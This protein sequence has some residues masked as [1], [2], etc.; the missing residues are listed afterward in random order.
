MCHKPITR[1]NYISATMVDDLSLGAPLFAFSVR[2]LR[3][4]YSGNCLRVRRSNDNAEQDI[5]FFN[6]YIDTGALAT[7]VGANSAYVVTWYD[8]SGNGNNATQATTDRQ[9]KL[10]ASGANITLGSVGKVSLLFSYAEHSKNDLLTTGSLDMAAGSTV[11]TSCGLGALLTTG[12]TSAIVFPWSQY[13][14]A[15]YCIGVGDAVSSTGLYD[16][17]WRY[18]DAAKWAQ[19]N[20]SQLWLLRRTT[21]TSGTMY[22][23]RGGSTVSGTLTHGNTNPASQPVNIGCLDTNDTSRKDQKISEIM[24]WPSTDHNANQAAIFTHQENYFGT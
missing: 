17:T 12:G 1:P 2:R 23:R 18:V 9:P 13:P 21:G 24:H 14:A 22:Y 8:Q 10:V 15:N 19:S 11:G 3:A 20:N 5:A 7:F 4:A 16:G 6:D